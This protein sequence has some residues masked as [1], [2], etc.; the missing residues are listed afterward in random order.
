M[1]E[2]ECKGFK[3]KFEFIR[4]ASNKTVERLKLQMVGAVRRINYMVDEKT[5]LIQDQEKRAK[6]TAKLELK[7]VQENMNNKGLRQRVSN[8][9]SDIKDKV[10]R[11]VLE[12][13]DEQFL[14]GQTIS[15]HPVSRMSNSN[16]ST[17]SFGLRPR[18]SSKG[19]KNSKPKSSFP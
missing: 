5:K 9:K 10:A 8:L 2:K 19:L 13:F 18:S 6:Y 1:K 17:K 4:K 12:Q 14:A 11:D 15:D 7:I 16:I 3:H